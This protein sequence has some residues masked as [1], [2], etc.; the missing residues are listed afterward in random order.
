[1]DSVG[2]VEVEM[3]AGYP[4]LNFQ[5]VVGDEEVQLRR[6]TRAE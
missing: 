6:D 4:F 5:Q 1:M 2:H 3:P